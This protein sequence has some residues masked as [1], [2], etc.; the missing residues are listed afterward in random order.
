MQGTKIYTWGGTLLNGTQAA[1]VFDNGWEI[2]VVAKK[3]DSI[4][5]AGENPGKRTRGPA[6]ILDEQEMII[7]GGVNDNRNGRMR[8]TDYIHS[9]SLISKTW[10][11]IRPREGEPHGVWAH[12][13]IVAIPS[14]T[15]EKRLLIY[16]GWSGRPGTGLEEPPG[17][18]N[19]NWSRALSNLVRTE[20]N[21]TWGA[22]SRRN[23]GGGK[24]GCAV[25]L[26]PGRK[27]VLFYGGA[28][29]LN[30]TDPDIHIYDYAKFDWLPP[31]LLPE[32][33]KTSAG[34]EGKS[35]PV[36]TIVLIV[37][38]VL[39]LLAICGGLAFYRRLR[40]KRR[41]ESDNRNA[42]GLDDEGRRSAIEDFNLIP[43]SPPI[44]SPQAVFYDSG[45][46]GN[47]RPYSY[48]GP[49]STD[50]PQSPSTT[51]HH[52]SRPFSL[53]PM[54]LYPPANSSNRTSISASLFSPIS[55]DITTT[56]TEVA[57]SQISLLSSH[58]PP[59]GS[60]VSSSASP[61]PPIQEYVHHLTRTSSR[62][63]LK[64][65]ISQLL[66]TTHAVTL[67]FSPNEADELALDKGDEVRIRNV[68]D[69]GS[70]LCFFFQLGGAMVY[71]FCLQVG[72]RLKSADESRRDVSC[73]V[74]GLELIR[75][76]HLA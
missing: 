56:P 74:F 31:N 61:L 38:A 20:G 59:P 35:I 30:R 50:Q 60:Y 70:V 40:Q 71:T 16:G 18:A 41:K 52:H 23:G 15:S 58:S 6:T 73:F 44:A 67:A 7:V 53:P 46:P 11:R 21:W 4:S 39:L 66:S 36:L 29:S 37:L 43:N 76:L 54:S 2:D 51:P 47:H 55:S 75:M 65:P 5:S 27:V 68:W 49:T 72:T 25:G 8:T 9:Y 24:S 45:V 69:D 12:S 34:A 19:A 62:K 3:V 33:M 63:H 64:N 10:T 42:R 14:T 26:L 28:R 57:P 17:A 48:S 13:S 1:D 32:P 22:R